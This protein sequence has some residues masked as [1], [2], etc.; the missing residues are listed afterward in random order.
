MRRLVPCIAKIK[1][2]AGPVWFTKKPP[3]RRSSQLTL[4][5]TEYAKK[6]GDTAVYYTLF[7][8]LCQS[9][10]KRFHEICKKNEEKRRL[11]FHFLANMAKKHFVF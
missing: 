1:S 7:L 11:R 9:S 4:R 5:E 3:F 2:T 6:A 10:S 8:L